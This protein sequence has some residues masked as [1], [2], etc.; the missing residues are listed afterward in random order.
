M[1]ILA[2]LYRP[3]RGTVF[4]FGHDVHFDAISFVR[5]KVA[6]LPQEPFLFPGTIEENLGLGNPGA[7]RDDLLGALELALAAEIVR[8]DPQGLALVVGEGGRVPGTS[9]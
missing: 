3:S 5:K 2:G 1:K 7:S 8:G 9:E 6:Y 4:V